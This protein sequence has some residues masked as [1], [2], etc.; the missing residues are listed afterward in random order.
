MILVIKL[1]NWWNVVGQT[2]YL[3]PT[4]HTTLDHTVY[5]VHHTSYTGPHSVSHHTPHI[6]PHSV[7]QHT[8][9]S[10]PHYNTL[11]HTVYHSTHHTLDHTTTHCGWQET[12]KYHITDHTVVHWSLVNLINARAISSHLHTFQNLYHTLLHSTHTPCG[13]QTIKGSTPQTTYSI[14]HTT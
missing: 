12:I 1:N 4:H 11:D 6:G 8:S 10:G 3:K 5:Q 14:V 13:A 2:S 9:H 7:S